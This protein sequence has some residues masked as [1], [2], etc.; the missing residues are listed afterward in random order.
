MRAQLCWPLICI[1]VIFAGAAVLAGSCRVGIA[2]EI[3]AGSPASLA[4]PAAQ[5]MQLP[6]AVRQWYRNP[7]GS[8]VQC[9]IGMCGVW[10]NI[11]AASTLLWN[12]PYGP[13]IRGGSWP[14]RVS[15]Y[16]RRRGIPLY[17]ITGA[18]TLDWLRWAG[19]T[20]RFAAMAAG[21]AHFQTLY[22]YDPATNSWQVCNN[23]SPQRIDHYSDAQFRRLHASGGPWV[24]I[25]D[26]PASPA[27]P[28][29]RR[30]W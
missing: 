14:S 10:S 22:G 5:M 9:S 2:A 6:P 23:N 21:P 29:Y 17:N 8:C 30:W 13:A 24:V 26:A 27:V 15:D 28:Q 12:T 11:P 20:G 16:A 1:K 7:D 3:R 4:P 19:R 18:T 25:L